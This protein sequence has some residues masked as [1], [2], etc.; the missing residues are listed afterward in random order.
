VVKTLDGKIDADKAIRALEG[1]KF[2]SPRGPI[3]IDPKTRDI[4]QNEHVE[5]VVEQ[6]DRLHVKVLETIPQVKDP[7]KALKVGKCAQ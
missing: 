6:G 1:W 7:C 3:M 2:D 5:E 4:V